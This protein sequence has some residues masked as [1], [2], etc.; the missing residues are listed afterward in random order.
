MRNPKDKDEV[1]NGCDYYYEGSFDNNN[2]VCLEIGMGKGQFILNMALNNPNVNYIGV[3]KYS[4]VASVAI[5][6][7]NEYKPSNLKVLIG[8]IASIEDL[9]DK[10]IDTIYLNFSDPWPKD[11]HKKRRLTHTRQLTKYR[12]FLVDGG[13]IHFKTDDDEL[14][15]ESLEYFKECNFEITYITRDLHNSGY[16]YNVV[17]EHEEMFS[18]QGIK[19]KFLIAKK[20]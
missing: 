1:L 2:P 8:D 3:E 17:T 13:E 18:K 4:S 6:K 16:E 20:L 5:K 9:L 7:I 19:I 12:D 15:E 10:K 14:F 11:R